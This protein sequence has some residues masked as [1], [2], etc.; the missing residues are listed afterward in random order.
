MGAAQYEKSVASKKKKGKKIRKQQVV[1]LN[2]EKVNDSR[3]CFLGSSSSG[4][5]QLENIYNKH[6]K[7]RKITIGC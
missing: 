5:L 6:H 1:E 4:K 2:N 3:N 7:L